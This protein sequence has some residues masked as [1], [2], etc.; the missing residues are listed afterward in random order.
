MR[1]PERTLAVLA[2]ALLA[3]PGT[4]LA[5]A[6]QVRAEV[7]ARQKKDLPA[8]SPSDYTLGSAAFDATLR[9]KLAENPAPA[10]ASGILAEGRKAWTR[11]L[12][13]GRP[14]A[15]RFP[16]DASPSTWRRPTC[17]R[18]AATTICPSRWA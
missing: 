11:K 4:S 6:E 17:R 10:A 14:L 3:L 15:P 9:A 1:F 2:F 5:A 8:L 13:N 16:N 12:K 18:K 7:A